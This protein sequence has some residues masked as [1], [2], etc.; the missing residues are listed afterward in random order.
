M[1]HGKVVTVLLTDYIDIDFFL[2]LS[3]KK[4]KLVHMSFNLYT[5]LLRP[6]LV[7]LFRFLRSPM[8]T[9]YSYRIRRII[10]SGRVVI[11]PSGFRCFTK[12]HLYPALGISQ[13]SLP[14]DSGFFPPQAIADIIKEHEINLS[15]NDAETNT[16]CIKYE[17]YNDPIH[18][19]GIKFEKSTYVTIDGLAKYKNQKDINKL[20][21][22]TYGY[23]TLDVKNSYVLA[24]YNWHRFAFP[25]KSPVPSLASNISEVNGIMNRR[26]QRLFESCKNAQLIIFIYHETQGYKFMAIDDEYFDLVD[27][28]PIRSALKSKFNAKVIVLNA[29]EIKTPKIALNIIKQNL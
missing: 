13:P 9:L 1:S 15:A 3:N 4:I 5:M 10:A 24:H 16:A 23:Y 19:Y 27:L 18:G 12:E 17:G 11:A 7:E 22:S 14:F 20:L 25:E 28:T 21:D 6:I 2:R 8:K 26:I 29:S